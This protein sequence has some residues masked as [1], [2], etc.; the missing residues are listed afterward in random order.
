VI[1]KALQEVSRYKTSSEYRSPILI[2]PSSLLS[3][4]SHFQL[5]C[6]RKV[7]TYYL[8]TF[9]TRYHGQPTPRRN[10]QGTQ[11]H[12]VS[13][14][15]FCLPAPQDLV[16]RDAPIR[17][18]LKA[19]AATLQEIILTDVSSLITGHCDLTNSLI[20]PIVRS[21]ADHQR[22]LQPSREFHE[23]G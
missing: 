14:A 13:S 10:S 16:A 15:E 22:R 20:A 18:T 11:S 2:I 17:D 23:R 9:Y 6:A 8:S 19:E 1:E 4:S 21:R 5:P 7:I 3:S 12:L